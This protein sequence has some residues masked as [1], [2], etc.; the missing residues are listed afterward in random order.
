MMTLCRLVNLVNWSFKP[1]QQ[2]GII[3]GLKETFIRRYVVET[4]SRAE[5]RPEEQ[6]EKTESCP[7]NLWREIQMKGP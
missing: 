3:L 4:T 6:S 1:S 5:I 2:L 7:E